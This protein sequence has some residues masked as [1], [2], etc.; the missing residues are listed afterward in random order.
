MISKIISLLPNLEAE[1][2]REGP[3]DEEAKFWELGRQ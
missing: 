1:S 2:L 3:R